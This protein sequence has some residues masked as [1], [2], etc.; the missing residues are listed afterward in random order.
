M[1]LQ[2]FFTRKD[3]FIAEVLGGVITTYFAHHQLGNK[4]SDEV[5]SRSRGQSL[6]PGHNPGPGAEP[7]SRG[8]APVQGQS[9]GP[10]A[11][12]WSRGRLQALAVC[13]R[14]ELAHFLKDLAHFQN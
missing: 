10:G 3:I 9:P 13:Q 1:N 14:C 12:S 2:T 7:R 11:E 4:I 6:G 5:W 8:R